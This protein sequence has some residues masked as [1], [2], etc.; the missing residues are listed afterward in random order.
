MTQ[1]LR[2]VMPR[3]DE[4]LSTCWWRNADRNCC[5]IFE[6]QRT[7]YGF[8][9]SFNSEMA[10]PYAA[11]AD[12]RLGAESRPR[13]ASGYGEWTGVKVTVHLGN[14]R[15]PPDSGKRSDPAQYSTWRD[16]SCIGCEYIR[17]APRS[18]RGLVFRSR[19]IPRFA[20]NAG[21]G[22]SGLAK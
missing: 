9:Y 14:V 12:A 20:A 8:C 21:A 16:D 15:K 5:E 6:V 13:K 19:P 7:E 17:V 11:S 3:C 4:L 1:V 22:A 18:R 2:E 10:E